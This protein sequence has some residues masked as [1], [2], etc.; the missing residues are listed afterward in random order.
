[1]PIRATKPRHHCVQRFRTGKPTTRRPPVGVPRDLILSRTSL[2]E[3]WFEKRLPDIPSPLRSERAGGTREMT[4]DSQAIR[5]CFEALLFPPLGESRYPLG[6]GSISVPLLRDC[7]L[8]R[9]GRIQLA[10]EDP[11]GV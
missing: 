10:M 2:P 9:I 1:M 5:V 6:R 3:R 4:D 8:G 7:P 11:G